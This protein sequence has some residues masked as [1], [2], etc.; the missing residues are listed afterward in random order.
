[1]R[2]LGLL[3]ASLLVGDV[4]AQQS[5]V[6]G[7][8]A[9]QLNDSFAGVYEKVAPAVVVIEVRHSSD[10]AIGAL[11]DGWQFFF[12]E[13]QPQSDEGSGFIISKDGYIL[14]NNHVVAGAAEDGIKVTLKDGRKLPAALVGADEKSDLAVIKIDAKDLTAVELGDSDA[15]KVGQFAFAIGAPFDL[16]YT[17]TVGVIS[18]K[19]R[20]NLDRTK[21]NYEE[22]I[23]TDASINPGNSG[24]PLCDLDGRVIG[25]NTMISG[26]NRGLGFAVPSNIAKNV[27]AQLI[28]S[29]RVSRPWLGI[30][31]SGLGDHEE[32]QQYFPGMDKGVVV[33]GIE[34][35]TPAFNSDLRVGDL[36]TK[37]DDQ[38]VALPHDL[39]HEI[40]AK[41]VG[42]E[43]KLE[44]WRQGALTTVALKTGEQPDQLVRTANPVP[45]RPNIAPLPVPRKKAGAPSGAFG[46]NVQDAPSEGGARITTVDP[47]S[48]AAAAGLKPDDII[49]EAAGKPVANLEDFNNAL[50][51]TDLSRGAMLSIERGGE[52]TFAILK[53]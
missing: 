24:G 49:T 32:M 16:P 41:K 26:M 48:A 36:I 21:P 10:R 50:A 11:P 18:A 29:G 30:Q 19:G 3:C 47:D 37:V 14:T 4:F 52:K 17:F 1:M 34:P 39:Q 31:I 44:V 8:L 51:E 27:S 6:S 5:P 13:G 25:I 35:E 45:S 38:S 23:Q 22:Y 2:L 9:H 7:A 12:R 43:V 20:S 46:M 15:A 28:A 33:M 42:Q 40:L 53:P